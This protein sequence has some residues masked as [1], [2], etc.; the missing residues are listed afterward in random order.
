LKGKDNLIMVKRGWLVLASVV[1]ACVFFFAGA[2]LVP[3]SAL[4]QTARS[5]TVVLACPL[6][7]RRG[8]HEGNNGHWVNTLKRLLNAH[9]FPFHGTPLKVNGIFGGATEAVVKH[10]QRDYHLSV[11]GVV[12]LQTWQALGQCYWTDV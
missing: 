12:G 1:L 6:I 2:G 4:A 11:D 10:Y 8:I 3:Q 9:Y 7:L 5:A